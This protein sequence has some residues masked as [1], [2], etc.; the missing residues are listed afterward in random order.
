MSTTLK[1]KLAVSLKRSNSKVGSFTKE[2]IISSNTDNA[3]FVYS[4][5]H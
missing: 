3:L 5:I 4:S 1:E 2:G